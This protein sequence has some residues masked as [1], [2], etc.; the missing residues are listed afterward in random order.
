MHGSRDSEERSSNLIGSDSVSDPQFLA[1][2]I[3]GL[4]RPKKTL[5]CK[6]F[7]D[8]R[9]SE[10]FEAICGLDEYYPTRTETDLLRHHAP[11]IARLI[12]PGASIVELGSGACV[13]VRLLLKTLITPAAYVPVDISREHLFA[14]AARIASNYPALAV[15]PVCFDYTQGF[16]FPGRLDPDRTLVFFPGS[17]IGN[18]TPQEAETF[19]GRLG[20]QLAAGTSLLIGVDLKKPRAILEAA[21]NDARGVTAAFNLNLLY[22]INRELAGTLVPEQFRHRATYNEG[23]GRIEMHLESLRSQIANIA[24]QPF[25]FA[26]G[27][28]I[29]TELSYKYA[30]P[31]FRQLAARAGWRGVASWADEGALFSIHLLRYGPP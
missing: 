21:Y 6:Y 12:G 30:V 23:I 5:P 19:L 8:Q 17:T 25:R 2:V 16:P 10:L 3:E 1:D 4:S 28:T 14:A 11:E 9:G 29:L 7:Y 31:E 24:G 15:K 26:A 22:R 18:F 20:A 13:K 27:E